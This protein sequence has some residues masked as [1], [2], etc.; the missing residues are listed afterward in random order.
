MK[1]SDFSLEVMEQAYY[2]PTHIGAMAARLGAEKSDVAEAVRVLQRLNLMTV[3]ALTRVVRITPAG[4][5]WV[6]SGRTR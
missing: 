5:I 1:L 3:E 4:K 6:E 2:E